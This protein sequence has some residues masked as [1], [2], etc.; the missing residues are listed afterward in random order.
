VGLPGLKD[1]V[2]LV[3]RLTDALRNED[4][5]VELP[6]LHPCIESHHPMPFARGDNV[7]LAILEFHHTI[8]TGKL[9]FLVKIGAL[10]I[11]A[12]DLGHRVRFFCL[13][14]L[15]DSS[16]DL[17][18]GRLSVVTTA[19]K[20]DAESDQAKGCSHARNPI[21][22]VNGQKGTVLLTPC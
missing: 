15:V 16:L 8:G 22:I 10:D 11:N 3:D 4:D 19:S 12:G 17:L 14:R 7:P 1:M 6:L 21:S 2:A 18:C 20:K 9:E 5:P 13:E